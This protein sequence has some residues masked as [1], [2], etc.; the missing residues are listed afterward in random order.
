MRHCRYAALLIWMVR[1]GSC[2]HACHLWSHGRR[3][4]WRLSFSLAL[5]WIPRPD[6]ASIVPRQQCVS[7]LPLG[8]SCLGTMPTNGH[9]AQQSGCSAGK[10]MGVRLCFGIFI[11]LISGNCRFAWCYRSMLCL[12]CAGEKRDFEIFLSQ[13][14]GAA[15][16]F[17]VRGGV[18]KN[19]PR[20]MGGC[21]D[22]K[23]SRASWVRCR[24]ACLLCDRCAR[25]MSAW[26]RRHKARRLLQV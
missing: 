7:L 11:F 12:P 5:T 14:G 24:C 16:D 25:C 26:H 23:R 2:I 10:G 18:N 17:G 1:L 15:V 22:L 20:L 3:Q 4:G 8:R 6:S 21:A 13:H 9:I 19:Y